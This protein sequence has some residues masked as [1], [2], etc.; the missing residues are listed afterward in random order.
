MAGAAGTGKRGA[1]RHSTLAQ[2]PEA[3]A[4]L[5]DEGGAAFVVV[6]AEVVGAEQP[7]AGASGTDGR[8]VTLSGTEGRVPIS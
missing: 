3:S 2:P 1:T 6:E 4:S 8:D 5:A 7:V